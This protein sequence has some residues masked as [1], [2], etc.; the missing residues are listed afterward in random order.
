MQ[1]MYQT[2]TFYTYN[3]RCLHRLQYLNIELWSLNENGF[4]KILLHHKYRGASRMVA[5]IVQTY[6]YRNRYRWKRLK[7][8]QKKKKTVKPTSGSYCADVTTW[9]C[10]SRAFSHCL[11]ERIDIYT[12]VLI[13]N[14]RAQESTTMTRSHTYYHSL[15]RRN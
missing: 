11:I 3:Q 7:K 8:K 15:R 6:L 9:M 13:L 1:P 4:L 10:G 12:D 14:G 5:V 2:H